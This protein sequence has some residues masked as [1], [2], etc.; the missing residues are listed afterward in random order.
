MAYVLRRQL[1]DGPVGEWLDSLPSVAVVS[2]ARTEDEKVALIEAVTASGGEGFMLKWLSGE[3]TP[4]RRSESVLKVKF[5]HTADCVVLHWQRGPGTGSAELGCYDEAGQ[6]VRVGACS[7]IGKPAVVSG[8][9]V[10]VAFSHYRG[11]MIQPRMVKVREDKRPGTARCPSSGLQQGRHLMIYQEEPK[12]H[13]Q[14]IG[15]DAEYL[16]DEQL[17]EIVCVTCTLAYLPTPPHYDHR[18]LIALNFH[19]AERVGMIIFPPLGGGGGCGPSMNGCTS[20]DRSGGPGR[21]PAAGLRLPGVQQRQPGRHQPP[22][23]PPALRRLPLLPALHAQKLLAWLRASGCPDGSPPGRTPAA[24][25]AATSMS[26]VAY[27]VYAGAP[28]SWEYHCHACGA[29]GPAEQK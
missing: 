20:P 8:D 9:V 19:T 26:W 11:A 4:G 2:Q 7:L 6:M 5:V 17:V 21:R 29:R 10:E 18:G 23:R 14:C 22:Q 28:A 16:W 3:Y 24:L 25:S 1:L 13:F 15:C 12:L 27:F